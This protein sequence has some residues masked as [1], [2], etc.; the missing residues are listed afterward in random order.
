MCCYALGLHAGV[1]D[2]GVQL[3]QSAAAVFFICSLALSLTHLCAHAHREE[4]LRIAQENL[5][6]K[7]P[8]AK[9]REE[10]LEQHEILQVRK[11]E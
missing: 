2:L 3:L 11:L 1:F 6:C 8:L 10:L 9:L 7:D 4:N 5:A